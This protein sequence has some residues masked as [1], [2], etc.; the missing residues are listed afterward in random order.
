MNNV[1]IF[2]D[3]LKGDSICKVH[4]RS[5]PL[6]LSGCICDL[7]GSHVTLVHLPIKRRSTRLWW[8]VRSIIELEGSVIINQ[9]LDDELGSLSQKMITTTHNPVVYC[10]TPSSQ[11][12]VDTKTC[13]SNIDRNNDTDTTLL[14]SYID[15]LHSRRSKSLHLFLRNLSRYSHSH[16]LETNFQNT[17]SSYQTFGPSLFELLPDEIIHYIFLFVNN[18]SLLSVMMTCQRFYE[19]SNAP[20]FWKEKSQYE[21]L[22]KGVWDGQLYSILD[23]EFCKKY[24]LNIVALKNSCYQ[25]KYSEDKN[26][27]FLCQD[28]T[29]TNMGFASNA[30]IYIDASA[31]S[32]FSTTVNIEQQEENNIDLIKRLKVTLLKCFTMGL[33]NVSFLVDVCNCEESQIPH[34][35]HVI[36]ILKP[37]L[38]MICRR[39]G[40]Q[41]QNSDYISIIN[42]KTL[43]GVIKN[44]ITGETFLNHIIEKYRALYNGGH[45]LTATILNINSI[46]KRKDTLR[47]VA[48]IA[49]VSGRLEENGRFVLHTNSHETSAKIRGQFVKVF[50]TNDERVPLINDMSISTSPTH[51]FKVVTV[52][53]DLFTT[54]LTLPIRAGCTLK[55]YREHSEHSGQLLSFTA[56]LI[57]MGSNSLESG[58]VVLCS[59]TSFCFPTRMTLKALLDRRSGMILQENPPFLNKS[60]AA[61]ATFDILEEVDR[62]TNAAILDAF[63]SNPT[64]GRLF[65]NT[66]PETIRRSKLPIFVKKLLIQEMQPCAVSVCKSVER[67]NKELSFEIRN[68]S[69]S[70]YGIGSLL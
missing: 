52:H 30:A 19:I 37:L 39:I 4:L 48:Q 43:E 57:V 12:S 26:I 27:I 18:T 15:R 2:N 60:E 63:P 53:F 65:F 55:D 50:P 5:P 61:L 58:E 13:P 38:Q 14:N 66:I 32:E 28:W 17:P 31:Y 67:E 54:D 29:N 62:Y 69:A 7:K 8:S 41:A 70:E 25:V 64:C 11:F 22:K 36:D 23:G 1:A 46:S 42:S 68:Y 56:Q 47:V 49:L 59:G 45:N 21:G 51:F 16:S 34:I 40:F 20:Q 44:N 33:K 24:Y 35:K 3:A 9:P 10:C 6:R